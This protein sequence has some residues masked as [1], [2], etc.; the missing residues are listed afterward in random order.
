MAALLLKLVLTP[1]LIGGATPSRVAGCP[2]VGGWI[3]ALPLTS[4]PVLLFLALDH[5]AAFA[6]AASVGSLAGL[7][8]IA[9]FCVG[10][11][12]RAERLGRHGARVAGQTAVSVAV[13][14]PCFAA[15]RIVLRPLVSV[16]TLARAVVTSPP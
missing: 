3:I 7:A 6:S 5:G 2:L 9:A 13:A 15:A 10:Y 12:F 4:G 8:A 14:S 11:A 1:L 16:S